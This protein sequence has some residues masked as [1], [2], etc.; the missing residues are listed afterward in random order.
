M[1]T[2]RESQR[3]QHI[4]RQEFTL[5]AFLD[6]EGALNNV[7]PESIMKVPQKLKIVT[8]LVN[9]IHFML[10]NRKVALT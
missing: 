3:K 4:T 8:P 10:T 2:G 7:H 6:I 1:H 5:I 9:L